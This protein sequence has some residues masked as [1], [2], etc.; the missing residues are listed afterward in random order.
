MGPWAAVPGSAA[1]STGPGGSRRCSPPAGPSAGSSGS[2]YPTL[3]LGTDKGGRGGGRLG[4]C[5]GSSEQPPRQR[6][7]SSPRGPETGPGSPPPWA[8][9]GTGGAGVNTSLPQ[10]KQRPSG[11]YDAARRAGQG[12]AGQGRAGRQRARGP[13]ASPGRAPDVRCGAGGAAWV[14]AVAG[15]VFL[16]ERRRRKSPGF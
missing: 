13:R 5:G 1:E 3:A 7:S 8:H 4:V 16:G 11:G 9:P 15:V 6:G 12:R 10:G 2:A 14:Q